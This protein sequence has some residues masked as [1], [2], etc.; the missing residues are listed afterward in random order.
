MTSCATLLFP[1]PG[2]RAA[3]RGV[4][5]LLGVLLLATIVG[6]DAPAESPAEQTASSQAAPTPTAPASRVSDDG[7]SMTIAELREKL[8]IGRAGEIRKVGG[9]IVAI[10]LQRTPVQ[11][12]SPL[13]GLPLRQ[14]Y[15]EATN[16]SDLSPLAGM[17]LE[18]LYLTQTQVTDLSPL[19]GMSLVEL[20]VV[21]TPLED[22]SGLAD[23]EIGTLWIPQTKVADLSP[24]AGKSLVSLD[25]QDTPVSDLTPLAGNQSLRRLHIGGT[26]VTDLTPLA[27]LRLE[28]LI[29]TPQKITAGIEGIRNMDSL[30]ALDVEFGADT[31]PMTPDTFWERYDAGEWKA[32]AEGL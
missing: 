8:G 24:L 22:L 7:S 14:L 6:C 18:Q 21:N 27:G 31:T 12:L 25:V 2:I 30:R 1:S 3:F 16:V 29:F 26:Q 11:D 13:A 5:P 9:E 17:P 19:A 10:D 15:L 23:V 32:E 20:N 4:A 28:R